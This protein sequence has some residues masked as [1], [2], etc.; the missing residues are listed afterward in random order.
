LQRGGSPTPFDRA[1]ATRFGSTA[2]HFV[3][4]KK[5]G[6][7]CALQCNAIIPV[8]ISAAIS[9]SKTVPVDGQLVGITRSL[10]IS[11]GD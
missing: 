6:M 9:K 5:F 7:M 1:L 3:A 11:F 2:A 10:G 4:E 8:P